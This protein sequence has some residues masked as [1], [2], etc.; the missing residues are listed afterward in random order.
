MPR[1]ER[2]GK[3]L[4]AN[5]EAL[6]KAHLERLGGRVLM[7]NF[8]CPHGEMDVIAEE[9]TPQGT[10]LV[11]VEVK[12]RRGAA[13]G[14]P[15]EAVDLRKRR[16]LAAVAQAYLA[17]HAGGGEEPACRFDVAEVFFGP[18]G[19][20]QIRLRRAAFVIGE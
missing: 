11:F 18:D 1:S 15:V 7:T 6:V 3:E 8:R 10:V 20:A 9:A 4:G 16:K 17:A 14:A 13:H 5:G 2:G 12:T 19:L